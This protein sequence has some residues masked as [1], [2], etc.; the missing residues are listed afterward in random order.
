S[1][2]VARFAATCDSQYSPGNSWY[3]DIFGVLG[4]TYDRLLSRGIV[5]EA[6]GSGVVFNQAFGARLQVNHFNRTKLSQTCTPAGVGSANLTVQDGT[7][8]AVGMPVAFTATANGFTGY[9]ATAP[10]IYVVLSVSGNT[11]TVGNSRTASALTATGTT[12]MTIESWGFPNLELVKLQS[13]ASIQNFDLRNLDL[14]G[15]SSA[16]LYMDGAASCSVM[17][18]QG[19]A[20]THADIALRGSNYNIIDNG[21]NGKL[22]IDGSSVISQIRGNRSGQADR[23]GIGIYRDLVSGTTKLSLG[24]A[25]DQLEGRAPS[26]GSYIYPVTGFGQRSSPLGS[27]G[28]IALNAGRLGD[29]AW[30]GTAIATMTLPT[31][32]DDAG[33]GAQTSYIGARFE[34]HNCSSNGSVLTVNTDGTQTFNN[35]TGKVSTTLNAGESLIVTGSRGNGSTFFWTAKKTA[36]PT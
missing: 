7:K 1:R 6:N 28:A 22:D 32:T 5:F 4:S 31:I 17:F 8:F 9:T 10:K 36:A 29:L 19:G 33:T 21:G 15:A 14:E 20:N 26:G 13:S 23:T 3:Q 24:G 12:G 27:T 18:S 16:S 35:Q 2:H 25:A 34:I 30:I 11:I